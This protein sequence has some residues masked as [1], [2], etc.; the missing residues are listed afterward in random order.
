M[1]CSQPLSAPPPRLEL[2]QSPG[3]RAS[4]AA[5][6]RCCASSFFLPLFEPLLLLV[7]AD[8]L[9]TALL[10]LFFSSSYALSSSSLYLLLRFLR[11]SSST[12]SYTCALCS[13]LCAPPT[14]FSSSSRFISFPSC[15]PVFSLVTSASSCVSGLVFLR[16]ATCTEEEDSNGKSSD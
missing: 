11:S 12:S 10:C 6:R 5:G 8:A 3:G 9:L 15:L 14:L 4:D 16:K 7:D 13:P 1:G 2:A